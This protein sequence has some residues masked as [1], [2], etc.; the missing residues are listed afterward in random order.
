MF[1]VQNRSKV[2]LLVNRQ[3]GNVLLDARS[4]KYYS[5]KFAARSWIQLWDEYTFGVQLLV[6]K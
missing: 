1:C 2:Y 3:Y 4:P 5:V 6:K